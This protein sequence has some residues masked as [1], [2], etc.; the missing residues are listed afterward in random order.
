MDLNKTDDQKE[1]NRNPAELDIGQLLPLRP[2]MGD[3]V[4]VLLWRLIRISGLHKVFE[5]ETPTMSYFIGKHIGEMLKV[6][7]LENLK[8]KLADLKIGKINFIV[9]S[10]DNVEFEIAECITC[11]GITPP[12]GRP[13]CQ[14]EAGI[15]A[16]ALENI[17]LGKKVVSEETKCIGG[18]GDKTCVIECKIV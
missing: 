14:L 3:S 9:N 15:I 2:T 17:Y 7:N 13:I 11:S 1:F 12:L 5:E 18:L 16:G 10:D 6:D 4:P 8:D